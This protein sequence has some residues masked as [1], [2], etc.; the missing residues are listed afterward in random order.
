M[1]GQYKLTIFLCSDMA[2]KM[3]CQLTTQWRLTHRVR[4]MCTLKN[5]GISRGGPTRKKK[6]EE[7]ILN[8]I[9]KSNDLF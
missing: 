3:S 5:T 1:N 9:H 8:I 4:K 2:R 6:G 7:V